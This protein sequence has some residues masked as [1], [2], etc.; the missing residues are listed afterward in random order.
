MALE[1]T[2]GFSEGPKLLVVALTLPLPKALAFSQATLGNDAAS[3]A[4]ASRPL[5]VSGVHV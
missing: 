4:S 2:L 3:E 1:R 5:P